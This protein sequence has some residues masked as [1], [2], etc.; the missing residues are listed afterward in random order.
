MIETGYL[1]MS[2]GRTLPAT[3]K[4]QTVILYSADMPLTGIGQVQVIRQLD[5]STAGAEHV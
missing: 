1:K 3:I 4:G 5:A 2:T